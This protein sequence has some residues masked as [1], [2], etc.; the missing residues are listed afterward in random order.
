MAEERSAARPDVV[1]ARVASTQHGLLT[2]AQART[3]GVTK[4]MVRRRLASGMWT[5][6][7]PGVYAMAGMPDGRTRAL[8]AAWLHAGEGTALSMHTAGRLH[9]FE[10][11][12][13]L[14]DI[15]LNVGES[16][17][18]PP[19]GIRWHRQIDMVADDVV[20][21]DGLPVT[22]IPRTAMDLAGDPLVGPIRLQRFVES[23]IVHRRIDVSEFGLVLSRTRRSGK[24]GVKLMERVLD[25]VGPGEDLPRSELERL[26]DDVIELSG[27]PQPHHEHP[28]PGARDRPGFVDRCW[29][30]VR[31]IVEADGRRWHTRRAQISLD[32]DRR[33]DAQTVG[34]QTSV[35]LWEHLHGDAE[36]SARRLELI[37]E[38]RARETAVS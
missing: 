24:T 17:R 22:S 4:N 3:S 16:W 38:Q 29:P 23:A 5:L 20:I 15:Y 11:A 6:V 2:R 34:F 28:L 18:H 33:L 26:L 36:G 1:A 37:Y 10:E 30:E 25:D 7:L 32:A 13:E 21:L 27:L 12:L 8:W 31:L 9:G 35:F 19:S 14:D